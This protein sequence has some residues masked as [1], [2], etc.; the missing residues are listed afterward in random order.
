MIGNNF[1]RWYNQTEGTFMSQATTSGDVVSSYNLTALNAA[2]N[3]IVGFDIDVGGVYRLRVTD[4]GVNQ[5][6][7]Q[8]V[9]LTA[10]NTTY[11]IA[12]AYKENSFAA[13]ANGGAVATDA[14]GTV[15]TSMVSFV[16]GAG[17]L[18]GAA[19][20]NGTIARIGYYNRRLAN[21]ELTAITS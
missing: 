1:A 18:S 6:L 9:T 8:A 7:V 2:S 16:I 15:P 5:A 21:T 13:T 19:S 20:W 17:S 3:S 12:G 10:A 4:T 14:V 11:K